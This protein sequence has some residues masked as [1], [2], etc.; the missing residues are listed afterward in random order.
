MSERERVHIVYIKLI[1]RIK[2]NTSTNESH[3]FRILINLINNY[4][5]DNI[6]KDK[7]V[8]NLRKNKLKIKNI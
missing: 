5:I 1:F 3:D 7:I 4:F 8:Y 2:N 6:L